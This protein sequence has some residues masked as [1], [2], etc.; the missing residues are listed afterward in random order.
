VVAPAEAGDRAV[1]ARAAAAVAVA[2][3]MMMM[4]ILGVVDTIMVVVVVVMV[5]GE[6]VSGVVSMVQM[7]IMRGN[8]VLDRS[9]E[10][11]G[12]V[13][14]QVVQPAPRM[15]RKRLSKTFTHFRIWRSK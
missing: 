8:A 6:E 1:A 10:V 12:Q 15:Y 5:M 11:M 2:V 13:L 3:M 7:R 14:E 9:E 4:R